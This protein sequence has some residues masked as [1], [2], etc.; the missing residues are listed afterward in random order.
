[1]LSLQYEFGVC[2][3]KANSTNSGIIQP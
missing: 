3:L 2:L 1:M